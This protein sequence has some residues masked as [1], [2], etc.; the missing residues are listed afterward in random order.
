VHQ[1]L[2]GNVWYCGEIARN[3][4][5]FPD[6]APKEAELVDIDGSWK[7][8]REGAKPGIIMPAAFQIGDVHREEVTLGEA[9]NVAEVA[10]SEMVPAATCSGDCLVT[11]NFTP[12]QPGVEELKY[13]A[14]EVGL[15]LEVDGDGNRVELVEF[16]Q[17]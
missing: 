13:Y 11:R 10:A 16:S 15:F 17:P 8:G 1:D 14:P 7:A 12:L 3:F 9:E 4:E 5:S 6:D 2:D